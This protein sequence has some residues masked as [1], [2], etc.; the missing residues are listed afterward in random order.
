METGALRK[1]KA[2]EVRPIEANVT[3]EGS[4]FVV[5]SSSAYGDYY[6]PLAPGKYTVVVRREG[7]PTARSN[8]T[9]PADGR[10][11]V[12]DFVMREKKVNADGSTLNSAETQ[13]NHNMILLLSGVGVMWGLWIVHKRMVRRQA[14]SMR[15]RYN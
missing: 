6:R 14:S 7:Y 11:V 4:N 3:I 2:K 15:Q 1:D 12:R 8:V 9:V 10:G 5:K 13:R